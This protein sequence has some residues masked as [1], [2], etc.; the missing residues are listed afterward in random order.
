MV[1][2]VRIEVGFGH[3]QGGNPISCPNEPILNSS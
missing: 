3:E 2:V 1:I